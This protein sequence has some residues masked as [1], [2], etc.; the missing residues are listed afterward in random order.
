MSDEVETEVE[1][2]TTWFKRSLSIEFKK[3]EKKIKKKYDTIQEECN[4]LDCSEFCINEFKQKI[5]PWGGDFK[6]NYTN[7]K[8]INFRNK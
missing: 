6:Y 3:E 8:M 7:V 2:T 1:E 5:P 4:G